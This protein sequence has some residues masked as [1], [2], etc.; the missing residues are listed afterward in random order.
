M[1]ALERAAISVQEA[2][3]DAFFDNV[4]P[5]PKDIARA[6]LM[7]VRSDH[8]RAVSDAGKHTIK[9]SADECERSQAEMAFAS[10]IDAILSE[11]DTTND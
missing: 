9:G 3:S 5:D 11:K 10:M 7:A 1:T 6:V 4:E 2:I 8:G